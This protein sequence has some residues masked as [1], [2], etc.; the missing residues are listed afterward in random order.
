MDIKEGAKKLVKKI[1][2]SS[3]RKGL[4]IKNFDPPPRVGGGANTIN[5]YY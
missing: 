1:I 3:G 4:R 2:A 5:K